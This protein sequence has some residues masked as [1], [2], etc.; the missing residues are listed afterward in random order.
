LKI[1]AR[2]Y[3]GRLDSETR[4]EVEKGLASDAWKCIVSTNALGM[5]ID[6]P[7]IRFIIHTQFPQSP[8]HYYQ[9]IG[10]AGRDGKP[11]VIVL[12]YNPE[13]KDLPEAFIEGG[14]PA[15][16]KYHKVISALQNEML[17]EKELM[18][19][20][21]LRQTQIRVIRADLM[22]QGIIREVMI[23]RTKKFEYIPNCKPLDTDVFERVR[24]AKTKDLAEM[25]RYAETKESRMRF[26]CNFLG[27]TIEHDYN[28]CDNT[29]LAKHKVAPSIECEQKLAA[30]RENYFPELEVES[31]N[32]NMVNGVAASYYGVSNVGAAI[33]RSKYASGGDFPDF[34]ISLLL[35]AYWKRFPQEKFDLILYVPPTVSG[36][37]V[38]NLSQRIANALKILIS[39]ALQK[40]R[41]TQEQKIYDNNYLKTDNVTDA[42]ELQDKAIVT[43]KKILL[44]DDIFD[45]G[46]TLKEIGRYL[47]K[48]GAVT[49]AP[50]V[51][52]RTL[53]GDTL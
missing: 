8:V 45:S 39:H 22:D 2:S 33:H 38:K 28:N 10:R 11:T 19:L 16:A 21:N 9:E 5:G 20:T 25:M 18:K 23:G 14:R 41:P 7:D 24:T 36:D 12:L 46:A 31:A 48:C 4:I 32:S 27:D 34:L 43:G 49:I 17:S 52:A 6:K 40:K 1:P 53:G 35:K 47:T 30:F 50:L 29:G 15:I 26:L 44:I 13:D 37:L 3:N 51:L 42:F